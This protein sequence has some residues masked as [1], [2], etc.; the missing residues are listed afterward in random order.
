M[1]TLQ[2]LSLAL[3]LAGCSDDDDGGAAATDFD[4]F[5]T[6][7]VVNGTSETAEPVEIDGVAFAFDE[8]PAAFD[9][10]LPPDDGPVVGP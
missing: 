10:V 1:R 6:D 4:A 7:V 8:D 3:F 5:V 2:L 9:D